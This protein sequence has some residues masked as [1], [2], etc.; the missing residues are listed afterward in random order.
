MRRVWPRTR[1]SSMRTDSSSLTVR[2]TAGSPPRCGTSCDVPAVRAGVG[3]AGLC[4]Q[5]GA[6][7]QKAA[8]AKR[9]LMSRF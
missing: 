4:A 7:R 3:G 8:A 9:E 5:Q 6:H 2:T 1:S